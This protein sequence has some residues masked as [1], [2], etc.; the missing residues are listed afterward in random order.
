MIAETST[1]STPA[2]A[3]LDDDLQELLSYGTAA[4]AP[5]I[6]KARESLSLSADLWIDGVEPM[7]FDEFCVALDGS[8][9]FPRQR[10]AFEDTGMLSAYNLIKPERNVQTWVLCWG[11]GCLAAESLIRNEATGETRTAKEW[12]E[13]NCSL[14]VLSLDGD[15]VGTAW[16]SPVYKIGSEPL[17]DVTLADGRQFRATAGHRCLTQDGWKAVDA[18]IVAVDHLRCLPPAGAESDY[19]DTISTL[20][21]SIECAGFGDFYDLSVPQTECYFD[22]GGVLHHNSGKGFLCAK[23][24]AWAAYVVL[25]IKGDPAMYL[26]LAKESKLACMNVAPSEDLARDVFF[27]DL[28]RFIGHKMFSRFIEKPREQILTDKIVFYRQGSG[29]LPYEVLTLYSKHSRAAG[30]EGQNL[31]LWVMD[32]ADDFVDTDK[33]SNADKIHSIF[34]S[35]CTTRMGDRWI[36][37]VIS[38]P[39]TQEGFMMRLLERA[40]T[41]PAFYWDKAASWEVRP[42]ISRETQTVR[43]DYADDPR[44]A[45]AYYECIPLQIG[46]AFF[47]FDERIDEAVDNTREPVAY[48]MDDTLELPSDNGK[49]GHYVTALLGHVN[50]VPGHT[51]FMGVDSGLVSDAYALSIF[52]TDDSAESVGFL[53]PRCGNDAENRQWATYKQMPVMT[54]FTWTPEVTVMCGSCYE[55]PMVY[56]PIPG[57]IYRLDA[58]WVRG[59][60]TKDSGADSELIIDGSGHTYDLPHV[61][62]DLLIQIKPTKATRPGEKNRPVYFP[63]VQ[64]LCQALMEQ[65]PVQQARFDPWNTAQITQSLI[66]ATGRDI[67]KISFSAPDQYRRARLVKAMLYAGKI[68]LL[69]NTARDKEWKQLQ[70]VGSGKVNH[71]TPGSKDLFDAESVAIWCAATS[72]CGQIAVTWA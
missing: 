37:M 72:R 17:Y 69:P 46:E 33:H 3:T 9:M 63:G 68:T 65:L 70:R 41:S 45:A 58:W 53:C 55:E 28:K 59:D 1:A 67:D 6:K 10:K 35:S 54:K 4:L 38:Y 64:T 5:T 47:E 42:T 61:Y 60:L 11:K 49:V 12:A 30:L 52:H 36:G 29:S 51:Y 71:P 56:G 57:G 7:P 2:Q 32:E 40:K 20:I 31:L 50:P 23:F 39:R 62:E 21:T 19:P 27:K 15:R 13:L 26:G 18:L 25:H 8:P 24:I 66:E 44:L 16:S 48:V 43:D 14:T 22:A 34:R